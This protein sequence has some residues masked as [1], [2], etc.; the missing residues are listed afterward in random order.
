MSIKNSKNIKD[1]L[2]IK[3]KTFYLKF[4][5]FEPGPISILLLFLQIYSL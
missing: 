2:H 4:I 3:D 5:V 1:I